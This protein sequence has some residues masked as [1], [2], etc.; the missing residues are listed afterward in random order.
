MGPPK[1]L[2][3]IG[4]SL[5]EYGN[6]QEFFPEYK[7]YSFGVAGETVEGVLARLPHITKEIPYADLVFLMS[8]L[9]NIAI[10]DWNFLA[11][12]ESIID[13]LSHAYPEAEIFVHSLLPTMLLEWIPLDTLRKANRKLQELAMKKKVKFIDLFSHF[14]DREG[15]PIK[16]YLL[17]DGVHLTPEGYRA[18]INVI[19]KYLK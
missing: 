3:F 12:Y 8:G 4:N 10:D 2:L 13:K 17:P 9:N 1:T 18:W 16:S 5:I 6:W 11:A 7:V 19:E 15:N 14:L